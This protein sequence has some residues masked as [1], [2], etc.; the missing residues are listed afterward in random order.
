LPD[1]GRREGPGI[2]IAHRMCAPDVDWVRDN[3]EAADL[4]GGSERRP[5]REQEEQA[6]M[7][8]SLMMLVDRKLSEQGHWNRGGFVALL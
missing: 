4:A 3:A 8:L 5:E 2:P 7:A 1:E 6:G